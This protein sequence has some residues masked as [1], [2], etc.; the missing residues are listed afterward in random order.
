MPAIES[1]PA[2]RRTWSLDAL[3]AVLRIANKVDPRLPSRPG[4]RLMRATDDQADSSASNEDDNAVARNIR[5]YPQL[6]WSETRWGLGRRAALIILVWSAYGV[7]QTVPDL[8]KEFTWNSLAGQMIGAWCWALLTPV[9]LLFDYKFV[10]TETKVVKAGLIHSCLGFPFSLAHTSLT[11][12]FQY[13]FPG[14]WWS[15]FRETGFLGF[16]FL[17]GW[18]TYV[19]F[20]AV[21]QV[22]KFNSRLAASQIEL[23]RV[24]RRLVESNLNALRLQ[25]EPHFLFNALNAI[26]SEVGDNPKLVRRMIEDLGS[27]LRRSIECQGHTEISLG[28]ELALLDHYLSIQRLRFGNRIKID[29]EVD[30]DT[31]TAMVPSMLLQPMIENAIRHGLEKRRAGGMVAVTARRAGNEILIKVVDD[32]VGLPPRWRMEKCAGLGLRVTRER[33]EALYGAARDHSFEL[34]RRK[35]GGTQVTICIPFHEAGAATSATDF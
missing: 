33:L 3:Q 9:I 2:A 32:G 10:Q 8:F 31:L 29:V 30:P 6:F 25:L 27:L 5:A 35:G 18:T 34:S 13:P 16:Y 15:P 21:I 7:L 11:G 19:C 28:E 20:V 14:I 1:R 12:A 23:E 26:S 17:G 24:E 4:S 22:L